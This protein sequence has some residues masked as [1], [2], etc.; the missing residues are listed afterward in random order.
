M[1]NFIKISS[2]NIFK[3]SLFID[4]SNYIK[5]ELNPFISTQEIHNEKFVINLI[6]QNYAQINNYY[7]MI[8][9]N[10]D[11]YN[12]SKSHGHKDMKNKDI[13][14]FPQSLSLDS[15]KSNTIIK[16]IIISNFFFDAFKSLNSYNISDLKIFYYS[17]LIK[18]FMDKKRNNILKRKVINYQKYKNGYFRLLSNNTRLNKSIKNYL[19][20]IKSTHKYSLII[21][22]DAL[23]FVQ[24]KFDKLNSIQLRPGLIQFLKE[25]KQFYELILYSENNFDYISSILKNF[26]DDENKYFENILSNYKININPDGSIDNLDLLG[27]NINN[28]IFIDD[29]KNTTKFNNN[30]IIYL[31]SFYGN[32][33]YNKNLMYN[34]IDILK[35]IRLDAEEYEDIKTVLEK[36]KY[37]I[38]T[39][40]TNILFL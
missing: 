33:K 23:I 14:K 5:K 16:S 31:K 25:M 36:Y 39:K 9:N 29:I 27:R 32:E 30:S 11:N 6:K 19:P 24:N 2:Y 4:L 38:F 13:Y 3:R 20:P 12:I 21:N 35:K 17:Y 1:N 7:Q 10:L 8:I 18:E 15:N 37:F 28:I 22:L 26:E 40:I 34:L